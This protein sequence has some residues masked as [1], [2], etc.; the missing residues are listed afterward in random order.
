MT[1]TVKDLLAGR[2]HTYTPQGRTQLRGLSD[3][4]ELFAVEAPP[5]D[6]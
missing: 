4:W 6:G 1:R 2:G 5:S 3:E